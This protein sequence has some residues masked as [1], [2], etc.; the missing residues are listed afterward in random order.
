MHFSVIEMHERSQIIKSVNNQ[1]KKKKF[2]VSF[3]PHPIGMGKYV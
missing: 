3:F 2:V 1:N